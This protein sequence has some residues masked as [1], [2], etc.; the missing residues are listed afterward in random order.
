MRHSF[1]IS[2]ILAFS[3]RTSVAVLL[4]SA[5]L[6]AEETTAAVRRLDASLDAMVAGVEQAET[7]EAKRALLDQYLNRMESGTDRASRVPFLGTRNRG[8]LES[9]HAS[10]RGFSDHLHGIGA[11][12]VPDHGLNGFAAQV[13]GSVQNAYSSSGGIYL[14]TGAVIVI[15]LILIIL[16]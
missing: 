10:F 15:L 5:P 3:L 2:G 16:L 4:L 8:T 13:R 6:A 14:S 1:S 9:L 11:N 12:A 7:P